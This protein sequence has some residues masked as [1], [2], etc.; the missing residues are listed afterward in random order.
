MNTI[1]KIEV[2]VELLKSDIRYKLYEFQMK[3]L[4]ILEKQSRERHININSDFCDIRG[5][6]LCYTENKLLDFLMNSKKILE[7]D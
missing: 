4:K 1:A 2:E 3:L 7:G 6:M 5:D